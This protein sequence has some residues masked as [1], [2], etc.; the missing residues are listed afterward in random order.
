MPPVESDLSEAGCQKG[1]GNADRCDSGLR[2]LSYLKDKRAR[3]KQQGLCVDC[4]NR[5]EERDRTR[6]EKCRARRSKYDRFSRLKKIDQRKRLE[7]ED[8]CIE[9]GCQSIVQ[10]A[11]KGEVN[12]CEECRVG[13]QNASHKHRRLQQGVEAHSEQDTRV[14]HSQTNTS[15][16]EP[17]FLSLLSPLYSASSPS[18][19]EAHKRFREATDREYRALMN[20]YRED[21]QR[22]WDAEQEKKASRR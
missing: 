7:K 15:Q 4:R 14:S 2:R 10:Q 22:R 16:D 17:D 1:P 11:D 18:T 20:R 5:V 8:Q 12:R 19:S 13:R 9:T 3:R 21:C 6:C